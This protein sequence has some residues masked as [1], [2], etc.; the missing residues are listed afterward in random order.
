MSGQIPFRFATM[1]DLYVPIIC[2]S[3]RLNAE[4]WL[5]GLE[6]SLGKM[7]K[8]LI[9]IS[10]NNNFPLSFSDSS[11]MEKSI[12][13]IFSLK[14]RSRYEIGFLLE[15]FKGNNYL[16][17]YVGIDKNRN[18]VQAIIENIVNQV[19]QSFKESFPHQIRIL[20]TPHETS[21][22]LSDRPVLDKSILGET[23]T[24]LTPNI[25]IAISKGEMQPMSYE[26]KHIDS[27]L[28]DSINKIV[29]LQSRDWVLSNH[30]DILSK[31]MEIIGSAE[32]EQ[33]KQSER[34]DTKDFQPTDSR[35]E[36]P[37]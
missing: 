33:N 6:A 34:M 27:N 36:F 1:E 3:R 18:E 15:Q 31:Y 29:A 12:M 4:K 20:I 7:L 11:D 23:I 19:T 2:G 30:K 5:G 9:E 22:I 24:P 37:T 14:F 28:V 21:F 8:N 17:E 16:K 26:V 32:W 13:G 35:Y 25:A 10:Q